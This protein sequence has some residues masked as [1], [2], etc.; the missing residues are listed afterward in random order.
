MS[1][2]PP[3]S[4][5]AEVYKAMSLYGGDLLKT[6]KGRFQP[7]QL[8][9]QEVHNDSPVYHLRLPVAMRYLEVGDTECSA[10]GG[11]NTSHAPF[12]PTKA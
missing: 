10:F 9:N 8:G 3:G 7:L 12:W 11:S 2:S 6:V 4:F 1:S 5:L